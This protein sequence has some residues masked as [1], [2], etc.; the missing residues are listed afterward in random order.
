[1]FFVFLDERDKKVEQN[2]IFTHVF[3]KVGLRNSKLTSGGKMSNFK[4]QVGNLNFGQIT[5]G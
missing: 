3:N 2:Y 1:M 4:L 5:S